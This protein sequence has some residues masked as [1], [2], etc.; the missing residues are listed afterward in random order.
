MTA[1]DPLNNVA[2]TALEALAAVHGGAQ[3]LHT[4]AFDEALALP[5]DGAARVARDTQLLLQQESGVCRVADPWG[6]SFF[7]EA[8]TD[9]LLVKAR[10]IL[11]AVDENGG[12]RAHVES[13][14]AKRRIEACAARTQARVDGGEDVV[15]G[16]NDRTSSSSDVDVR[17]V[18]NSK[19]LAKQLARLQKV[20][21]TRDSKR[22][23]E[24]LDALRRSAALERST[25]SFADED[26][27]VARSIECA[28]V[29]CTL[30]EMSDALRDVWGEHHALPTAAVGSYAAAAPDGS[31]DALREECVQFEAREGRRPK[32]L[33]A[34]V[35]MDGHDRGAN[36]VAAGLVDLGFEVVSGPL[37]AT[38][39]EVAA[40]A[41]EHDVHVVGVSTMAA[42]HRVLVPRVVEALR[43]APIAVVV[44][45]VVPE[46]DRAALHAA[47]VSAVFGPGS[48][49]PDVASV[50]PEGVRERGARGRGRR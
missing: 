28:R 16:V 24:A 48:T 34:K 3:S 22:C 44:G 6:G 7:M 25:A 37:F 47:G 30:G 5:S 9:D 20:R 29:R 1:Q 42:G 2:R 4:N 49:L 40:M 23:A 50:L 11:A 27:L 45:G 36:V 21:E 41:L 46:S 17:I 12:M 43:G 26:N 13:G 33:I 15:V 31:L 38:P 8:L 14:E 10:E 39:E 35:G 32:V 19:A 18:D